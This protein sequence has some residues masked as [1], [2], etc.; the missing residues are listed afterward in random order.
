MPVWLAIFLAL[1]AGAV[2]GVLY[3]HAAWP[4]PRYLRLAV[5][6]CVMAA[7][8]VF[9]FPLGASHPWIGPLLLLVALLNYL[10]ASAWILRDHPL[11]HDASPARRMGMVLRRSRDLAHDRTDRS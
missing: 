10:A 1:L 8:T 2:A 3:A 4:G 5:A 6:V 11:M 9:A 7:L